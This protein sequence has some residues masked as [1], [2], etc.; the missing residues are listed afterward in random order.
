MGDKG[1]DVCP[2]S[3]PPNPEQ[4]HELRRLSRYLPQTSAAKSEQEESI[5]RKSISSENIV[6][7]RHTSQGIC[8][9]QTQE[10]HEE[11]QYFSIQLQAIILCIREY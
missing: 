7:A 1:S 11:S 10:F 3:R 6:F 2:A 9:E 4:G 5:A 8:L